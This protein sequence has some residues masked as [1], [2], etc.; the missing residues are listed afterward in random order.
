VA[1]KSISGIIIERIVPKHI[2]KNRIEVALNETD[3]I[4]RNHK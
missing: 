4:H 2:L 3:R 1:L